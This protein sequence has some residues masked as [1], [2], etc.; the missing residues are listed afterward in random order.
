V[1]YAVGVALLAAALAAGVGAHAQLD[2]TNAELTVVRARL[3]LTVDRAHRAQAGLAAVT[4]QSTD[5]ARTL[6]TETS[7]LASVEAQ[8]ASTESNVFANGVSIN[9][10]NACLSGVEQALNQ[11]SLNDQQGA[12]A[13]LNGVAASC[14]ASE[15]TP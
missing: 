2:R 5:A 4:A 3:H 10:L 15:P 6:A 1:A 11:I 8:L 9:N 13:T 7:Q 12:A 14:R